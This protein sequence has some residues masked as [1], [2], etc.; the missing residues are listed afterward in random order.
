MA[1]GGLQGV[2]DLPSA[3]AGELPTEA[4]WRIHF[5]L[6]IQATTL[7]RSELGT[8]QTVLEQAFDWLTAHPAVKPHLEVETYTWQV[9]P[10]ELRPKTVV[11]LQQGLAGEL[12]WAESQLDQRGLLE[13]A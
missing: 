4:P 1:D 6:P 3:L 13:P 9:L 5:H 2:M 10:P 8:T 7:T 11:E 12:T